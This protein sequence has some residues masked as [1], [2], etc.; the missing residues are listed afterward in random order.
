[1]YLIYNTNGGVYMTDEYIL[2]YIDDMEKCLDRLH[3]EYLNI[4]V[5]RA[6][7]KQVE[8]VP[9]EYYGS[10]VPLMQAANITV[11]EARQLLVAPYDPSLLKG[12]RKSLEE[13]NLGVNISDDGIKIRLTFPMLTEERRVQYTKEAKKLL[14][15]CK[16]SMRN[17]RKDV[18][19]VF[20]EMK[21]NSEI[22]EDEYNTLEKTVQK[23]I[24][25]YSI[26]ADAV[27]EKKVAEIMEV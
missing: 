14:E 10:R 19:D 24:D 17:A 12:I 26:K 23:H 16:I 3:N 9:V 15:N 1:M 20:K 7:P 6:N 22:S 18:L 5:G 21:K 27:C 13:A 4:R 2:S 11:P 25:E 8:K